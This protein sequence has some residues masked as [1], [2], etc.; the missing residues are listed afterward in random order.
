VAIKKDY[1]EPLYNMGLAYGQLA[2][3]NQ[4]VKYYQQ[5][6]KLGHVGAQKVLKDNGYSW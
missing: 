1:A 2:E 3:N 6:A 5:A 4:A